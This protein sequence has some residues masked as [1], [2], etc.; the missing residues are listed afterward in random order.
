MEVAILCFHFNSQS[1][2]VETWARNLSQKITGS[3][4]IKIISGWKIY[5]PLE[6]GGSDAIVATDG[7][8]SVLWCRLV[9]WILGKS[10]VVFGHSGPG[11]DDKWNLLCSPNI[12]VAFSEPQSDWANKYKLPWTQIKTIHHAVDTDVF[13]PALKKPIKNIVLCVAAN[14]VDKRVDL[15][16]KAVSLVPDALFMAVGPGNPQQVSFE[17][18][19]PIYQQ[20]R[21]LCF[22]PQPWEAFG[23]VFLEAMACNLPVVTINDPVRQEIVGEAGILVNNPEDSRELAS[24]IQEALSTDWGNIPRKQAEKFSWTQIGKLYE[25]LFNSL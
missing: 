11:A 6:W 15:V 24:A 1:R 21:I 2:G 17:Q 12:F 13:K 14:T 19:P 9:T 18:M 25:S 3:I 4:E 20:A 10:L 8:L 5:N 16:K 23:L 22:T 7:R